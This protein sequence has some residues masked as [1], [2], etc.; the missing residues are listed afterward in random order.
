[1]RE[2]LASDGG[3]PGASDDVQ[4]GV[5]FVGVAI[6]G[7]HRVLEQLQ[8]DRAFEVVGG[9]QVQVLVLLLQEVLDRRQ[10]PLGPDLHRELHDFR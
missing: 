2:P 3:L 5:V 7:H 4:D 1:M 8:G 6:R 10:D 9:D